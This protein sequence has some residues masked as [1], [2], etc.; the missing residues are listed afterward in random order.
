[1]LDQVQSILDLS[2]QERTSIIEQFEI[3]KKT[4][5]KRRSRN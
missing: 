3:P 2:R 5:L 1:M 4:R